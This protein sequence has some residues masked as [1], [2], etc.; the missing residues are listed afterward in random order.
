MRHLGYLVFIMACVLVWAAIMGIAHASTAPPTRQ[1]CA[2]QQTYRYGPYRV[3]NDLFTGRRGPS[4]ITV[5]GPSLTIDAAYQA[6][7][8]G[9]VAYPNI[10]Y[11]P[12][13]GSADDLAQ[14]PLRVDD[15]GTLALHVRSSC[16]AAG[17]WISDVDGWVYG[18]AGTRTPGIAEIVIGLCS[19]GW[20]EGGV[21]V[22][23]GPRWYLAERHVTG[24]G[25]GWPLTTFR[26]LAPARR[27]VLPVGAFTRWMLHEGWLR[28]G[29]WLGNVAFGT[30]C[31]SGCQGL[32]DRL[33][34]TGGVPR[35][36]AP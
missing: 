28:P 20:G 17:H 27:R 4:C 15:L 19:Q 36:R 11:G 18:S 33:V 23:I 8:G 6:Q 12:K 7:P 34:V 32:T 21:R 22:K 10:R 25:A 1:T 13:F 31:W 2:T 24:G 26:P 30:E 14:L 16:Q 35:Y 9:V 5:T 29:E 3:D